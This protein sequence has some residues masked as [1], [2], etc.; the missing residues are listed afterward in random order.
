MSRFILKLFFWFLGFYSLY[1]QEQIITLDECLELGRQHSLEMIVARLQTQVVEKEKQSVGSRFLPDVSLNGNQNYNFGSTIDPTT[2]SRISSNIQS[3]V[4]SLDAGVELLNVSGILETQKQRLDLEV[5][6]WTEE[7]LWLSYKLQLIEYYYEALD[8][9]NWL[10]IQ[11]QQFLNSEANLKRIEK[12]VVSGARPQ[13]DL[14]DIRV[15]YTNDARGILETEHTLYTKKTQLFYWISQEE[16][17]VENIAL[18]SNEKSVVEEI[19]HTINPTLA[20]QHKNIERLQKERQLLK[21]INLP[22]LSANYSY[23]SFY[24]RPLQE[25]QG[26]IASFDQQLRDNK[27]H[28]V[29]LRLSIPIFQGG[30]VIRGLQKN[31][32]ALAKAE[33]ELLR[34]ERLLRQELTAL[35]KALEQG[36]VLR[37]SLYE[38]VDWAERS[39]T[40]NQV[41]YEHD[42]I[43]VFSFNQ[44]KNQVLNT[45]YELVKNELNQELLLLKMKL[46]VNIPL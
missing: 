33:Q 45:K 13:S 15:V 38:S 43:D 5:A 27:S 41:K 4:F 16:L 11:K 12:E 14:Y 7:E 9:Q 17:A 44:S 35:E 28:F 18:Q 40:T 24:S 23:G 34:E 36:E 3:N 21:S 1:G 32:V 2:N 37:V 39:F 29:G 30:A 6:K 25:Q 26:S 20:K 19:A 46:K 42:K 8:V 22:R 10:A 31:K